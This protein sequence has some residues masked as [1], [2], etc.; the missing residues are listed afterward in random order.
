V[1]DIARAHGGEARLVPTSQGAE[2]EI[3]IPW[4]RS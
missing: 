1:R 3:E 4:S 2:F